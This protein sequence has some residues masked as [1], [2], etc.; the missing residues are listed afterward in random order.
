MHTF[1]CSYQSVHGQIQ[2]QVRKDG[3]AVQLNLTVPE[4]V[5]CELDSSLLSADGSTVT[6]HIEKV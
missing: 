2:V 6:A 3:T 4:G 5:D 1:V